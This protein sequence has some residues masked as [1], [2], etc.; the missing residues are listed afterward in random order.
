MTTASCANISTMTILLDGKKAAAAWQ[1]D[2]MQDIAALKQQRITPKLAVILIGHHEPSVVYVG[3]KAKLANS[4]GIDFEKVHLP[5]SCTQ[6]QVAE[7]IQRI[8][9]DPNTHG[10][11]LQLPL[12]AHLD[13]LALIDLINPKK[14]VDGLHPI[15]MGLLAQKRPGLRPCT[16]FGIM[17]LLKAYD[18]QLSGLNATI[19]GAS[20]LVGKPLAFEL[21][22]AGA[23]PT[24]CHSKS[25]DLALQVANADIVVAAAGQRHLISAK[26]LKPGA[27]VIDVGIHRIDGT[28]TGDLD[29]DSCQTVAGAITPVPGGVGPMTVTA[30]MHN[31]IAAIAWPTDAH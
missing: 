5:S 2:L 26:D 20:N 6:Q 24:I 10:L 15:N 22:M 25:K 28:L 7:H 30:L 11:F 23:T 16:P 14:D 4:L 29:F 21:I 8:N 3:R 18:I 31:V 27:V 13:S 9:Q 1:Q 17:H 12:P 19:I